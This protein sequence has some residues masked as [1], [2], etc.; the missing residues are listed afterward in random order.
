M[1]LLYSNDEVATYPASWY[2]ASTEPLAE[3]TQLDG[4]QPCDVCVIGA[5]YTGLSTAL[6]LAKHGAAVIVLD[7]HRVGWG[8]SGRNGGQVGGGFNCTPRQL[9]KF[10]G[11]PR[12]QELWRL[13]DSANT[14]VKSLIND[15]GI[16]CD[17]TAGILETTWKKRHLP[18]H[19]EQVNYLSEHYGRT[20]LEVL[21]KQS[22]A[23]LLGS[24]VYAGGTMDPKG[25][26][27]HPLKYAFGLASAAEAAGVRIHER[28][29]VTALR[30]GNQTRVET[31][32]G[33]VTANQVVLACNGYLGKLDRE[34]ATRVMPINNFIVATEPLMDVAPEVMQGDVAVSDSQFVVNYFRRSVDGRLLFGGGENYSYRFPRD[35]TKVVRK[36][37]LRVFPQLRDCKIDYAWGGTLA[38]TP[39][40][41]PCFRQLHSNVYSASGYS[42]HGVAL[43]TLAGKVIADAIYN[44]PHAFEQLCALPQQRFPG[45]DKL[46]SA[47]LVLAMTYGA[48]LDK[49][50]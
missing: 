15:H 31:T 34:V 30:P 11:K 33:T 37:M 5:G 47:L 4:S 8:A 28:S 36:P 39:Y 1:N 2:A 18:Y 44:Q 42:G 3:F 43:A 12:A 13:A 20:E 24:D 45:G 41:L 48:L 22:V 25:G 6:H 46:R 9:E 49:L 32:T 19:Q 16:D 35:I 50:P 27:L 26:H 7:A 10:V 17:Y 23:E 29:E 40:R 14:L 21:D 38:I